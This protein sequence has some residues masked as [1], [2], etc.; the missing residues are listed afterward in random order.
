MFN[1]Y[2]YH[3]SFFG[4]LL[5]LA[6]LTLG[7]KRVLAKWHAVSTL[8][9][10]A[11]L[12]APKPPPVVQ[13]GMPIWRRILKSRKTAFACIMT[14]I[15]S[16]EMFLIFVLPRIS[17]QLVLDII[18]GGL[19]AAIYLSVFY[20]VI[21][22]IFPVATEVSYVRA[23]PELPYI[24]KITR[25][26]S[27]RFLDKRN[28]RLA[29]AA[30]LVGAV[31]GMSV[32][33]SNAFNGLVV[34]AWVMHITSSWS[35]PMLKMRR[36]VQVLLGYVALIVVTFV[37]VGGAVALHQKYQ[38][39][40]ESSTKSDDE[41]DMS[42][43]ATPS[44]WLIQVML[45]ILPAWSILPP[46]VL[47]AANMRF[48]AASTISPRVVATSTSATVPTSIP[49]FRMPLF[50]TSLIS[51]AVSLGLIDLVQ[52]FFGDVPALQG[53]VDA[54]VVHLLI[55]VPF[56]CGATVLVA[57]MR[58]ELSDWWKYEETW[59]PQAKPAGERDMEKGDVE[60]EKSLLEKA[61]KAAA[62]LDGA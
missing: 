45:M 42:K 7:A 19:E 35:T 46:A 38:K 25:V 60:E 26:E 4:H 20:N 3:Q 54:P 1:P 22:I 58:G 32:H 52:Y 39:S 53:L 10:P 28:P 24:L 37:I 33:R 18:W 34:A 56:T 47:V 9:I 41:P 36:L 13:T 11:D 29:L 31:F 2:Q 51:L 21:D 30:L 23:K 57:W 5:A 15:F 55:T 27:D 40:D 12:D 62:M 61:E 14:L 49:P 17:S 16:V 43:W 59:V 50:L 44:D 8:A 6:G 48:D